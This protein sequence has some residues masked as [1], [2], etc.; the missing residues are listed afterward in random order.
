[1]NNKQNAFG[2]LEDAIESFM[3]SG[4]CD[5]YDNY[6]ESM[7]NTRETVNE[8]LNACSGYDLLEIYTKLLIDCSDILTGEERCK[9]KKD[10]KKNLFSSTSWRN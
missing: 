10:Y 2:S 5:S 8:L 3:V 6:I 9:L 4:D 1:M 7:P